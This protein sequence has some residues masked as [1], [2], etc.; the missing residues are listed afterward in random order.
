MSIAGQECAVLGTFPDGVIPDDTNGKACSQS[1]VLNAVR[2]METADRVDCGIF[3]I[4]VVCYGK[5]R[6]PLCSFYLAFE[7]FSCWV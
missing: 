1:T 6:V 4:L 2:Q 3:L 7:F 5:S